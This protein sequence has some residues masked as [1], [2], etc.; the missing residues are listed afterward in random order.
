MV[1]VSRVFGGLLKSYR[2]MTLYVGNPLTTACIKKWGRF[3]R[4]ENK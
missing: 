2:R 3:D 4:E 1:P